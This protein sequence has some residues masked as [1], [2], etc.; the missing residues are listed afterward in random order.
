[1]Q[2]NLQYSI[3]QHITKTTGLQ[4]IWLYDGISLP[5]AKPFVTVEQMPNNTTILSKQ[6]E[7]IQTTYRFQVG[8]YANS[9]S[10]RAKLQ[11]RLKS[12]IM[13]DRITI[14]DAEN[15]PTN[16]VGYFYAQITGETPISPEDISDKTKYHRIYFDIEVDA[17]LHKGE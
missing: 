3:I 12:A 6:R 10:E 1:M 7:T 11:D 16:E 13:F 8:L 9:A 15:T 5:S 17:T 2:L 4:T 14:Y